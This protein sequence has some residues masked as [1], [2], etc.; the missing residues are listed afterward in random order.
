MAI[1]RIAIVGAGIG[2]MTAAAALHRLG[3][4]ADVYE[5][6]SQL[7]EVGAGLQLAPNATKVLGN[8]GLGDAIAEVAFEPTDIVSLNWDDGALR[9]R[10]PLKAV[11]AERYGSP[12]MMAH[13]ADLHALLSGVTPAEHIHLGRRCI[14]IETNGSGAV[15]TF[16][17]GE[18]VEA[19]VVIAADGIHSAVRERLFGK[20][21]ARFTEQICWRA[22]VPIEKVPT[23]LGPDGGVR[24]NGTEYFRWLGPTGHVICYPI[25]GGSVL[26]IFAG[27]VSSEWLDESWSAPSSREELTAAYAGWDPAML[28][29]FAHV[30]GCFKW[31]IYDRDPL[32]SWRSGR[33]MLMGDAAYPMMPTLAQGAAISM[34]DGYAAALAL[35]RFADDPDRAIAAF[36]A[37]R[38]PRAAKVQLQ[39]RTQFANNRKVP[40][41]PPIDCD[42]IYSYDVARYDP[43]A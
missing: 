19:D 33:V 3:L 29:M 35:S 40:A 21:P 31:G 15:L 12:Y 17:D 10:E 22:T 7:G 8:L 37:E 36:D 27:R 23:R 13:R 25:R 6:A 39:A 43:A 4:R 5:Q 41:P 2:G 26:N 28:E 9:F 20:A 16:A 18:R 24:L 30:E 14:D 32:P 1:G 42:W 34:E 38:R 11:T